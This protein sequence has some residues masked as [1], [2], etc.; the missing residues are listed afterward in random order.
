MEDMNEGPEGSM[1]GNLD[2]LMIDK[3]PSE[4]ARKETLIEEKTSV[5]SVEQ[6]ESQ[7]HSKADVFKVVVDS[8]ISMPSAA[9]LNQTM[10]RGNDASLICSF[11]SEQVREHLLSL[12][13]WSDQVSWN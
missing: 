12:K 3:I 6:V 2:K 7:L 11:T 10:L 8:D 1:D 4:T 13:Q 9:H 5:Q